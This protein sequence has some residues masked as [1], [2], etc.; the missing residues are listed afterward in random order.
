MEDHAELML[1]AGI[2]VDAQSVCG[3]YV[4]ALPFEYD[5]TL[6]R[7]LTN[8]Q[9]PKGNDPVQKFSRWKITLS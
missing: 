4:A 1:D 6:R 7:Q 9:V 2:Q 8:F 3:I 5:Y